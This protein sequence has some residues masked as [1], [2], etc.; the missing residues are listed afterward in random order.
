M[1]PAAVAVLLIITAGLPEP[2][3]SP[4]LTSVQRLSA[5]V[6][7]RHDVAARLAGAADIDLL[8]EAVAGQGA[9]GL[10]ARD[11][12]AYQL[13]GL[14]YSARETADVVSGRITKREL[15]DAH[16]LRLAGG[17]RE[18]ASD[19]LDRRYRRAAPTIEPVIHATPSAMLST[20]PGVSAMTLHPPAPVARPRRGAPA[21]P[22]AAVVAPALSPK[23]LVPAPDAIELAIVK[24]ARQHAVDPALVR[25]VIG[26]ESAFVSSARSP[27]GA[28]GLMQLMPATARALG[29]DPRNAE[30]NIEGGV[31]YLAGLIKMFGGLELALIA[32]NAGPGLAER[33]ARGQATLYGETR[34]YV[35]D[36][37]G[38]LRAAR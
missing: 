23:P 28:I 22:A 18:A 3:R 6:A 31:R 38:R 19:Y 13:L 15:D 35:R 24:Y 8:T 20:M 9:N 21:A 36:V 16:A 1:V 14:G 26:V 33:Y 32:Y 7:A 17:S 37:L 25:A 10:R 12:L 29:V 5:Q 34:Q 27:V 30:Q 11:T 4:N 2:T